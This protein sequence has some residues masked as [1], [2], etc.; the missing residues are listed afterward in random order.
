METPPP[1]S[2]FPASRA[3]ARNAVRRALFLSQS[4]LEVHSKT[5]LKLPRAG[6]SGEAER[7]GGKS[8]DSGNR[9][10]Q[11]VDV[12]VAGR[13]VAKLTATVL[14]EMQRR[15]ARYGMVTMCAG[16]GMG[17]AGIFERCNGY[18]GR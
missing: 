12:H 14:S 4:A 11:R 5:E 2:R 18:N 13:V 15:E 16:G 9:P 6:G 7:A 3:R 10:G 17:A 1:G 8:A